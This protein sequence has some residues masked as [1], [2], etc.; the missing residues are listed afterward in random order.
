MFRTLFALD[1][2]NVPLELYLPIAA[3]RRVSNS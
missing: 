2:K 3:D 1:N